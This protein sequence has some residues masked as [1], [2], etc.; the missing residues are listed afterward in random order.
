VVHNRAVE[1]EL[2]VR[3]TDD[4]T[5]IAPTGEVDVHTAPQLRAAIVEAEERGAEVD[6]LVDLTAVTFMDSTGL[7]VLVGALA[8]SREAGQRLVLCGVGGRI[9]RLLHLT[10]L[11]AAF[12]LAATP[13]DAARG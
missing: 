5:V 8:R 9:Q 6:V 2:A 1:L 7:G 4:A 10:G 13:A 11:D 12:E 3:R